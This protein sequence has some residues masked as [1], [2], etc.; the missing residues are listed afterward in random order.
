MEQQTVQVPVS[1]IWLM[2]CPHSSSPSCICTTLPP[3]NHLVMYL[4][5]MLVMT[6]MRGVGNALMAANNYSAENLWLHR[7]SHTWGLWSLPGKWRSN[8]RE[9]VTL[10]REVQ[11]KQSLSAWELPKLIRKMTATL[12]GSS[13]V[14]A[15]EESGH[16]KASLLNQEAQLELEWWATRMPQVNAKSVILQEPDKRIH[17]CRG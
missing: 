17:P 16:P 2:Q 6:Q 13:L 3:G 12:P 14:P 4:D 9:G 10:C 8:N 15:A 1:P 11:Q 5:N 7:Q